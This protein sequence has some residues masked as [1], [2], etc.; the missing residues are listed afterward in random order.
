MK[1]E[2][3]DGTKPL[4]RIVG[5]IEKSQASSNIEHDSLNVIPGYIPNSNAN[6]AIERFNE[7]LR[8]G[9]SAISITGPYG[10]GKS[11]F[12]VILNHLVAPNNDAGFRQALKR[13]GEA[14]DDTVNDIEESR[15]AAG[16]HKTGM[17]RCVVTAR[18]EPVATTILRA[19]INGVESYFGTDYDK[20]DFT[21]A[22]TLR[23]L[24]KAANVPDAGSIIDVIASLASVSPVFLMIDEFGK[25]IEYFAD[26]GSDGDLFLL[27]EL[28][29]MSG[30]SRKIPLH[31]ITMQHMAFG[32]YVAGTLGSRM[33][34]W[35]KIQGRFE[36]IHFSN[37][38][39]HTRAVLV[40][41]LRAS[42]GSMH[43]I[44][45]WANSQSDSAVNDA[46]VNIDA[47]L[48]ASCYP[49]HPLVVEALPELCSRYGQNAR[50][51]LSFVLG[52]G[53]G[54]VSRF[55]DESVW[56]ED[57]KL[58]T[59]GIDALYDYF[60]SDSGTTRAGGTVSSRLVEIDTII[61]DVQGLDGTR[62]VT[63]KAIGVLNLIGR[64]G[65]LRAS[66]GMLRCVVGPDVEQDVDYLES[67]SLITYRQHAD[68]YRIWHGTDVNIAAKLDAWRKVKNDMPF[69]DIMKSA[70]SPEP[71]VAARHGIETGTVR[72]FKCVFDA[73]NVD[74]ENYD[75]VVIYGN[76]DTPILEYDKPVAVS[77]CGDMSSLM[78]AAVEVFALRNVMKDD[79]VANDHVARSET[80]ERLAAAEAV[81]TAEFGRAYGSGTAWAYRKDNKTCQTYGTASSA[82]SAACSVWY[83]STPIIRN[84][85]INRNDLTGQGATARNRLMAA[86]IEKWGSTEPWFDGWSPERAVY[87]T[88][89]RENEIHQKLKPPTKSTLHKPWSETLKKL[90]GTGNAVELEDMY[91]VWKAPPFG[92]KNGTMPIL[93][94][95]MIMSK[96][97][98]IAIYEHG[99]YVP[100]LSAGLA[101]RLAKNPNHFRIKW[102]K[103]TRSRK[104]L[105]S[106]ASRNLRLDANSGMLGIVGYVVSVV[107]A[108]PTYS[109]R[110]KT[111]DKKTL[112]VRGAVQNAMEPDTLLFESIPRAM[113]M[114][115]LGGRISDARI[116]SFSDGL[117]QSI[118]ELHNALGN[119]LD[120]SKARLFAATDTTDRAGL[121]RIASEILPHISDHPMKV[122]LGAVSADIPDDMEWMKYVGLSL[123]DVP[124]TDWSDED[125]TMFGN[126]LDEIS[127]RFR[128]LVALK[129]S[130]VAKDLAGP[131]VMV[132]RIQPDGHEE[133]KVLPVDD[134]RVAEIF[135][136]TA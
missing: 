123:T 35:G 32:E 128:R 49:L 21:H 98:R 131:S 101:E 93:A 18:P 103:K 136:E 106:E 42:D 88:M 22:I 45:D 47:E 24:A 40:S 95:M 87:D 64:S 12:G 31:M 135:D 82:A 43:R 133:Y 84:E 117:K 10:S 129:F 74:F 36:D 56:S 89:I 115:P 94:L 33:K 130:K 57:T 116:Q 134:K 11:T 111:L 4:S 77:R 120:A 53:P 78:T 59:M 39:E 79:D 86:I 108:L 14:Y 48:V 38:L 34:E 80:G 105:V 118:D 19:I 55:I 68:E 15:T 83:D 97:D 58:P 113:E 62:L 96:R 52:G 25:N 8:R 70:M 20:S 81:L 6:E 91:R 112:A 3:R 44:M 90:Q 1:T 109:R 100:K 71:V 122:F 65:R 110:T 102:F 125:V 17:I 60:I 76:S 132:L 72:I 51:L 66:I 41:S 85:M 127:A 121:A 61:R 75:G 124:P 67:R 119:V 27:Q 107:R 104:L 92:M 28:A 9:S 5:V 99:T 26:G 16:I 73:G 126:K 50:T 63:L 13:I 30:A 69:H 37:S 46:G 29:E 2:Q 7:G 54:T 23:R 114:M